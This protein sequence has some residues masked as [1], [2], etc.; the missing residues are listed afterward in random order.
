MNKS[1]R[2]E[3]KEMKISHK[4]FYKISKL[5]SAAI[6]YIIIIIIVHHRP[7]SSTIV[8]FVFSTHLSVR[9]KPV[10]ACPPCCPPA[11][12]SSLAAAAAMG[13]L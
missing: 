2:T 10:G 8:I 12:A 5:V 3:T 13:E 4:Y 6:V 7:P 1:Q 11:A 9:P